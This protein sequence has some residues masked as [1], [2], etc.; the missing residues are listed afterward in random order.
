M[1]KDRVDVG[2]NRKL[3]CIFCGELGNPAE[4]FSRESQAQI[5][6]GLDRGKQQLLWI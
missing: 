1:T 6:G 2:K 5:G 4:Q 3:E